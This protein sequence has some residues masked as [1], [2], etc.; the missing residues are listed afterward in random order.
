MESSTCSTAGLLIVLIWSEVPIFFGVALGNAMIAKG[1]QKYG[2]IG[3]VVGAAMNILL[4]LALIPRY[5]ALGSAWATVASYS[6]AG[7]FFLLFIRNVRQ[8]VL[9][10][11][12]AAIWPFVF[13]VGITALLHYLYIPIWCKLAIA[14]FLYSAGVWFTGTV[15]KTDIERVRSMFRKRLD[16]V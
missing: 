13:A 1:L 14:L 3:A 15:Q 6:V 4:N 16:H 12:R 2:P 8:M 5:G 9:V 10:G 11:L 7:I